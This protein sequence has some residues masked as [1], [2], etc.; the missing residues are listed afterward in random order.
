MLVYLLT[1]SFVFNGISFFRFAVPRI[2]RSALF[3]ENTRFREPH[4][5]SPRFDSFD[6]CSRGC[7][8]ERSIQS[9]LIN[10][11]TIDF[12]PCSFVLVGCHSTDD[13]HRTEPNA[14]SNAG[15]AD[16]QYRSIGSQTDE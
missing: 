2:Y 13:L 5:R 16:D 10:I 11:V 12:D 1:F 6:L 4:A 15:S 8:I 9:Q 14:Q 3:D 7:D